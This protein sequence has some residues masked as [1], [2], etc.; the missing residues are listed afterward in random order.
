MLFDNPLPRNCKMANGTVAVSVAR[1]VN[2]EL[3]EIQSVKLR[4]VRE[5][6]RDRLEL[7][8]LTNQRVQFE[9]E[10]MYG[11]NKIV[12]PLDRC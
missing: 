4:T 6:G 5:G 11:P 9:I 3:N 2:A 7:K 10:N 1:Q 12:L 8:F